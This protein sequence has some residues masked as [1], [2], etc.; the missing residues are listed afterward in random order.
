MFEGWVADVLAVYLGRFI[1][2]E[3]DKLRISLWGGKQQGSVTLLAPLE[4]PCW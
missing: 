1:N 4:E 3:K 2:V